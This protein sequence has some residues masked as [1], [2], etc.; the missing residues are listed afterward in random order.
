MGEQEVRA[1]IFYFSDGLR[2]MGTSGFFFFF[3]SG[4]MGI[5]EI[6]VRNA[7]IVYVLGKKL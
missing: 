5:I 3:F 4:T 1:F 7:Y 6:V 2:L